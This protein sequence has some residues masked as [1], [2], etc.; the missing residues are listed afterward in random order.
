MSRPASSSDQLS[1]TLAVEERH[2]EGTGFIVLASSARPR[3][4]ARRRQ[5]SGV[6]IED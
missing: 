5:K 6:G 3:L 4:A 1:E 2:S